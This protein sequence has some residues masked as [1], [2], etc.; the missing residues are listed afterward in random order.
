M[1]WYENVVSGS[2][3]DIRQ[4]HIDLKYF[5]KLSTLCR[6]NH[7]VFIFC[8]SLTPHKSVH[9]T[10][11][12]FFKVFGE[13]LNYVVWLVEKPWK[14][15]WG[16]RWERTLTQGTKQARTTPGQKG[17]WQ[18][19]FCHSAPRQMWPRCTVAYHHLCMNVCMNKWI[20]D[21]SVK[22]RPFTTS[23]HIN[24]LAFF[25]KYLFLSSKI[26]TLT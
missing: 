10:T 25:S 18:P 6:S 5:L 16:L 2:K 19:R 9:I 12:I 14:G 1:H 17:R 21:C 7:R 4:C 23:A 3:A 26:K 13:N 11:S 24:V 20:T 22:C 15:G 8:F